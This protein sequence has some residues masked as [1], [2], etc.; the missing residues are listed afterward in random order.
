MCVCVCAD[1]NRLVFSRDNVT[2]QRLRALCEWASQA[3]TTLPPRTTSFAASRPLVPIFT[4]GCWQDGVAGLGAVVFDC[5][6]GHGRV[7][8]GRLPDNLVKAWLSEVGEQIIG[9]IELYAVLVMRRFLKDDIA[10][11]RTVFWCDNEAARFGLIRNES[12][13]RSMDVMLRAFAKVED[14][15]LSF[16]WISRVPSASN[17]SEAPSRGDGQSVLKLSRATRVEPFPDFQDSQS[18]VI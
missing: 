15:S 11:R 16:T 1:L 18:L 10:G 17:P 9:Q 5:A 14:E 2:P 4:D 3:L 12:H 8:P 6:T 13:S 7:F